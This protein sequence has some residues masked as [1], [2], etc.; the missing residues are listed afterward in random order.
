MTVPYKNK[1]LKPE[2]LLLTT[3]YTVFRNKK[4][5]LPR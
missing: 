4:R 1:T 5:K 2:H 3:T